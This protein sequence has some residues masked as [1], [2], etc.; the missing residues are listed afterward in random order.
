[1]VVGGIGVGGGEEEW[2]PESRRNWGSTE[3]SSQGTE[4]ATEG[5]ETQGDLRR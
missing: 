2:R 4:L 5:L 3:S 1:V